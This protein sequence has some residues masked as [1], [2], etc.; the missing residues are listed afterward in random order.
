MAWAPT[1][2]NQCDWRAIKHNGALSPPATARRTFPK[3]IH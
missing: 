2:G 1:D 3:G